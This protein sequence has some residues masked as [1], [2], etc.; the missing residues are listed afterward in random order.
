MDFAY[1]PEK[2]KWLIENR[3]IGFEEVIEAIESK[4][5]LVD[6]VDHFNKTRYPNQ[7]IYILKIRKY[8]FMVPYAI[9]IKRNI[10]FLKTIYANRKLK[11]KYLK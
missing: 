10:K 7:R 1:D 3:G 9:D 11:K 5:K 6:D 2:D 4:T 8:I